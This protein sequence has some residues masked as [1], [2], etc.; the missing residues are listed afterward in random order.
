M[1][2]DHMSAIV[3]ELDVDVCCV[4]CVIC[5]KLYEVKPTALFNCAEQQREKQVPTNHSAPKIANLF[6][7]DVRLFI[8]FIF[9]GFVS[10]ICAEQNRNAREK[11]PCRMNL[12]KLAR[13][14]KCFVEANTRDV[15]I[16]SYGRG[17]RAKIKSES[18]ATGK[19]ISTLNAQLR[20][21]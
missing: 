2:R 16:F 11:S 7:D 20:K 8:W 4:F 1:A 5:V 6:S 15:S 10:V 21:N 3:H 14:A 18:L 12:M 19:T 17:R 13:A 9:V